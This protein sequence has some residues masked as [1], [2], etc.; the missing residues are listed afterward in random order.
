MNDTEKSM[1]QRKEIVIYLYFIAFFLFL[2][3]QSFFWNFFRDKIKNEKSLI[4]WQYCSATALLFI[5]IMFTSTRTMLKQFIRKN[6]RLYRLTTFSLNSLYNLSCNLCSFGFY[7]Y[8]IILSIVSKGRYNI[9]T[10]NQIISKRRTEFDNSSYESKVFIIAICWLILICVTIHLSPLNTVVV[11]ANI[12]SNVVNFI[13]FVLILPS[14]KQGV[15][16]SH[17]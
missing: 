17:N 3:S 10:S 9:D 11:S 5:S 1:K 6:K 16:E 13:N 2:G 15:F 4:Y 14:I 12:F 8:C 7:I